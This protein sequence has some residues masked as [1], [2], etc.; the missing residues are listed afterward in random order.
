[1]L[2]EYFT[3]YYSCASMLLKYPADSHVFSMNEG[4]LIADNLQISLK[5]CKVRKVKE[6]GNTLYLIP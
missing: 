2:N 6:N 1:M 5:R 4:N 3:A